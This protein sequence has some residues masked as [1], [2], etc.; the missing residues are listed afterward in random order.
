MKYTIG[1][2]VKFETA[3]R[4][5]GDKSKCGFLHGHNWKAEI[6]I[7]THGLDDIGYVINFTKVKDAISNTFDHKT[8]L[9]H[10]D[11]L[12]I[13]LETQNQKVQYILGGN[14][15]CEILAE[16]IVK[17]IFDIASE[18]LPIELINVKLY[19]N[20]DSYAEVSYP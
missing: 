1:T 17:I 15:T 10:E 16:T 8:L 5:L 14:P 2:K 20:E 12:G 9:H 3:H 6:R 7:T 4:Q 18:E 13:I 19:E 11:S